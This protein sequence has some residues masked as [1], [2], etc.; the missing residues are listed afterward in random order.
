MPMTACSKCHI[1]YCHFYILYFNIQI[2]ENNQENHGNDYYNALNKYTKN[3][4]Y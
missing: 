1:L 2:N 4:L 3:N